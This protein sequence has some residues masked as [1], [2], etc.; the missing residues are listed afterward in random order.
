M[1]SRP[2]PRPRYWRWPH[3][4]A[5]LA[6]VGLLLIDGCASYGN[7]A[8]RLG[9][10]ASIETPEYTMRFVEA[11]DEGWLWSPKQASDTIDTVTHPPPASTPL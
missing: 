11:D 10:G 7:K 3:L 6:V 1:A 4:C 9:D 2:E 8:Y 5:L